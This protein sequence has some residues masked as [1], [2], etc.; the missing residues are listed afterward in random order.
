MNDI[1]HF[2]TRVS[3]HLSYGPGRNVG[4]GVDDDAPTHRPL[5]NVPGA[6]VGVKYR[7]RRNNKK[8]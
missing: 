8:M 6:I 1:S 5:D 7:R 4:V 3:R 2:L